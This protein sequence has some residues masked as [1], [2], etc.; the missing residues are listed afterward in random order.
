MTLAFRAGLMVWPYKV[1]SVDLFGHHG[2][3]RRSWT[4]SSRIRSLCTWPL[5]EFQNLIF[6]ILGSEASNHLP[7]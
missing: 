3:T 4:Y 5:C 2:E 7:T 1:H 6:L